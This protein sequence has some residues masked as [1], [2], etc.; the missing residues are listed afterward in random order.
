MELKAC[1]ELIVTVEYCHAQRP[2]ATLKGSH[3]KYEDAYARVGDTVA[4]AKGAGKVT[5]KELTGS[6]PRV[7]SF[8][9]SIELRNT[10]TKITHGPAEVFSKLTTLHWHSTSN[11]LKNVRVALQPF[12]AKD[13][14]VALPASFA[15]GAREAAAE[16]KARFGT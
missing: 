14:G 15:P 12:L 16:M 1:H 7:G 11:L 10:D 9:V 3:E 4:L 5:V 13:A 8:E 6:K 2:S